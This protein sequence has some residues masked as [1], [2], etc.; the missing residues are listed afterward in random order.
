MLNE[1]NQTF[2]YVFYKFLLFFLLEIVFLQKG[3]VIL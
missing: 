2:V 3:G 1:K